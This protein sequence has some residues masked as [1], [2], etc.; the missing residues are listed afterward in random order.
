MSCVLKFTLTKFN[1]DYFK[2]RQKHKKS[3]TLKDFCVG[4]LPQK[5][6]ANNKKLPAKI[7]N[8]W[9]FWL[10]GYGHKKEGNQI[11]IFTDNFAGGHKV[12]NRQ[13]FLVGYIDRQCTCAGVS[14]GVRV[15]GGSVK[16]G[17][18]T[19]ADVAD[20]KRLVFLYSSGVMP[21]L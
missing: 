3:P 14:C 8:R 20:W 5:S 12:D 6:N 7:K 4:L 17:N 21:Y 16:I 9:T 13:T 19:Y 1:C 10:A 18:R 11:L 2:V 15:I